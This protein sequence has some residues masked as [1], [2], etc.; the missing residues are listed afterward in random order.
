LIFLLTNGIY[1]LIIRPGYL[2]DNCG[3]KNR[4]DSDIVVYPFI[5]LVIPKTDWWQRIES[6]IPVVVTICFIEV[7]G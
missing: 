1:Y 7:K 6:N 4:I 5:T 2:T 3:A